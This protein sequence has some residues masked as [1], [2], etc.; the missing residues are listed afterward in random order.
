MA[1]GVP[2]ADA[3]GLVEYSFVCSLTPYER[4]LEAVAEHHPFETES[5]DDA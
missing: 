4:P 1:S 3:I 5:G 2:I